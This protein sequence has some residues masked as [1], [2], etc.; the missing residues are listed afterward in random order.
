MAAVAG[1]AVCRRQARFLGR[2]RVATV[3]SPGAFFEVAD[4]E[5]DD[6]VGAV[7]LI[8]G[9]GVVVG[10]GDERGWRGLDDGFFFRIR[11]FL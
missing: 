9:G 11:Y 2:L 5:F 8:S 6:G 1:M 10:V 4:G 3:H 7:E